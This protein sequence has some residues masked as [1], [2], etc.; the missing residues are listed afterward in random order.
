MSTFNIQNLETKP[1]TLATENSE[2]KKENNIL[3]E[4][5]EHLHEEYER[6]LHII[7]VANRNQYGAK[8]EKYM[9]AENGKQ[10][11][12]LDSI[13]T[14]VVEENESDQTE[15]ISYERK[16]RSRKNQKA[17]LPRKELIIEVVGANRIC[18]CGC[19]KKLIR[20]ETFDKVHFQPAEFY[21]LSEKREVLGC[22]NG[23][24]SPVTAEK[25]KAA[26]PKVAA[27][28]ELL[29][30]I[31]VSKTLDRQPLYHLEK[32]FETRYQTIISRQKMARWMIAMGA[33]F[34]P[35]INLMKETLLSYDIAGFDAT[36]LQVLKE[37][38][39]SPT[40]KSYAYCF[41]GGPPGKEVVLYDYVAEK[42][43]EFLADW[44]LDYQGTLHVDADPWFK[45]LP[46]TGLIN[47]CKCNAHARRKFEQIMKVSK[48]GGLAKQA[49]LRYQAIYKIEK[50]AKRL[51]LS[52]EERYDLRQKKTKP[53]MDE[54]KLWLDEYQEKVLPKSP[55]GK[56]IQ[57]CLNHWAG[58]VQ[59]LEDGR[60][61]ADNN[62]TE[63]QIKYFVMG[64][65]NW[66][67][68]DTVG[69]AESLVIHYGLMLTAKMHKL[70]PY[71]YYVSILN[72]LPHCKSI[73]DFE[74]LLPWNMALP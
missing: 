1:I 36:T 18:Q 26:L 61:E 4:R 34:Q 67:F 2:L 53:L 65:K 63:Q 27:T 43:K 22:P 11:L 29:S 10:L 68:T 9:D 54:F 74:S 24:E 51:K 48:K 30:H 8:S 55:I 16:K 50:E 69:G 38:G 5:N 41:R 25:P 3:K 39:R 57:Y 14:A 71:Q 31:A 6:L 49:V 66:M 60:L 62:L 42:H 52:P 58:L 28:E 17:N 47:L 12:L 56:A 46:L 23:C 70:D 44:F 7:K 73:E 59:F 20:Y 45:D 40:T 19:E 37:S 64:R 32:Q 72:Q 13:E 35:L 33:V 21:M 15:T